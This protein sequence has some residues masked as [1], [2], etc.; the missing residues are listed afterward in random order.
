M[1]HWQ[2]AFGF[3]CI[4]LLAW[5]VGENR[6]V[7]AWRIVVSGVL[8]QFALGV[9]LL[10]VPAT[11]QIFLM[12][13]DGLQALEQATQAGT[14]FVFGFLGG[15]PQPYAESGGGSTFV[16][17]FR[18]LPIILVISALSSL[19][20]YWRVL[21]WIV[22]MISRVFERVMGVGGAVALSTAANV[23]VGMVEAPLFVRPYLTQLS[24]GEL[25]IVMTCG[26]A[27]IA[28][29][30]MVLYASVLGP[31]I[32]DALGH[33][34][35]ASI[36][37]APAAVVISVLMV[38]PTGAPTS[39]E[40]VPPQPASSSMDAVTRGTVDGLNLLLNVV[41]LLI[42]LIA[43]VSLANALLGWLPAVDGAPI[44]L[45]RALGILLAPLAWLI[46]VPWSEAPAAGALL[47]VKTVLNEFVAYLDLARLSDATLSLRSRLLMTYALCGFANF[48]SLG[49]LIGGMAT[50]AP[51]RRD[52]IV[53]LGIKS[54]VAGTLAT[55]LTG[56]LVGIL[57]TE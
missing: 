35:I 51:E 41:A 48:G 19:L 28:G 3:C 4:L 37:S 53:G 54:I 43:L 11:Q 29:T 45:Q 22:R 1:N 32:P 40:L 2:S 26:M 36:I 12:L 17:A 14:A 49:I 7:I 20:F 30:M 15:A 6:R 55:C 23:F 47:G 24:R 52:E 13:N 27:G 8:L 39:G 9:V 44:T 33:I 56:A 10:K 50:M 5:V 25:F 21:P 31:V 38:P 46:G 42:V 34:L 16:L 18:A 57:W